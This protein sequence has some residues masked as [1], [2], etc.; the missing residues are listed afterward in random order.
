MKKIYILD[1]SAYLFR[2]Y[3]AIRN[4]TNAEGKSTNALYGFISSFLKLLKDFD[5]DHLVVVFDGPKSW[6]TRLDIY[7][8][9]KANRRVSP[10]DLSYQIDW[11]R[12]FCDL[13]GV[14]SLDVPNVEADDTIASVAVWA[15]DQ[16]FE[17]YICSED[18][19]LCQ[20]VNG[21]IKLLHTRKENKVIGKDE[22]IEKFGVKPEQIID[23]LA[24][25]GDASDNVPGLPGFGPKS[26]TDI[27]NKY[28]SLENLLKHVDDFS[29]KK[30]ET[31]EQVGDQLA[32]SKQLVT[33]DTKVDFPHEEKFF[34]FSPKQEDKLREFLLHKGFLRFLKDYEE[35][36]EK[37]PEDVSYRLIEIDELVEK[38][39]GQKEV[40]FDTET[41]SEHPLEAE[42]VGIGFAFKKGEAYYIPYSETVLAKLKPLFEDP[43]IGFYGHN[44]KYDAHVLENYGIKIANISFDTLLASYVLQ[45][46]ARQHSLD[47]LAL[48]HFGKVK[49]S[50][51]DLIGKG[52]NQITMREVPVEKVCEYCCEDVDYTLRLKEVFAPELKER[53]LEPLFY[54]LELPL[55][56]VLLK[57]ERNGI[58]LDVEALKQF[59]GEVQ[60]A[61]AE[62]SKEIFS[63]AGEEFNLNSPKQVGEVLF[64]KLKLP[65]Q[66]KTQTGYSTSAEVLEALAF[67]YPIA[68]HLLLYRTYEKLRST[69]VEALPKQIN[70][71]TGRIHCSFNQSVAATG[72]LSSTDPNLQNIPTRTELG[73]E[74]RRCFKP[75][76]EGYSFLACDYSQI[77]L[78]LLAHLSEDPTLIEAFQKGEDIHRFTAAKLNDID[79][80]FVTKEMREHA[81][82][83]NFGI[84]YGQGKFGLSQALGITQK[85]AGEF[86]KRY[87]ERYS[88]VKNFVD[89]CIA[90]AHETG[91]TVTLTGRERALAE[92]H[93]KN[94]I[95]MRAAERLAV[96]TPL[97]GTAADLIKLAMLEVDRLGLSDL[98]ILQIHDELVFEVPDNRLEEVSKA[99]KGAMEGVWSLKVPL[100]VDVS[101]GKN[102]AEC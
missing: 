5:P 99:V 91:K 98:M 86:I 38:L 92:I 23:Y 55:M 80:Q 82:A 74:I 46:G 100:V 42:L 90:K 84:I 15:Q 44:V 9:Y 88:K 47:A 76:K 40:C 61:L 28:G 89:S 60:K 57:M 79:E 54:D 56:K 41:T 14:P 34:R 85:Q 33:V 29:G 71:K 1:A 7:P 65:A 87:F 24:I 26:A 12:E 10:P 94:P 18:K 81:K 49:I 30:R 72:R 63:L 20:L 35:E 101:I 59:S 68:K 13:I 6:Q 45:A 8:E 78:R 96:N 39:K 70:P 4:M 17:V 19:D 37:P 43:A 64:E 83:V 25:V 52:K 3:Y 16:G 95:L 32:I 2:A 97:Q 102:W 51:T 31:L 75:Q 27:L 93:N 62:E 11:A 67:E 48:E 77:E 36:T 22:V 69:Y 21:K 53:G 73:R 50:I 66:K 58:Y